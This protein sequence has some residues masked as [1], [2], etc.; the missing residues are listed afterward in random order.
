[1]AERKRQAAVAL[2]AH[3]QAMEASETLLLWLTYKIS[4][5]FASHLLLDQQILI[6]LRMFALCHAGLSMYESPGQQNQAV[7]N[8]K[9]DSI[10]ASSLVALDA[11]EAAVKEARSS[12]PASSLPPLA[13]CLLAGCWSVVLDP[14]YS[15]SWEVR[16]VQ[17]IAR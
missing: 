13:A 4:P 14:A 7:L 8:P 12:S 6:N 16:Q 11:A 5:H 9:V 10:T 2:K 3:S 1:M 15:Y 17:H